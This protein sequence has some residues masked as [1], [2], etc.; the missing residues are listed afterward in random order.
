MELRSV[1]E[2]EGRADPVGDD[3]TTVGEYERSEEEEGLG[4]WRPDGVLHV[5]G[6]VLHIFCSRGADGLLLLF[7]GDGHQVLGLRRCR[8]GP[9]LDVIDQCVRCRRGGGDV[10]KRLAGRCR[11]SVNRKRQICA[12]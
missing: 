5:E 1:R 9:R 10:C 12:T 8:T 4:L 3:G 7:P 6:R 11:D 2:G